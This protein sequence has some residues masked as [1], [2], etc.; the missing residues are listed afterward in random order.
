MCA[1]WQY[2]KR[3]ANS[4]GIITG[5]SLNQCSICIFPVNIKVQTKFTPIFIPD[6]HARKLRVNV[7][8]MSKK[9]NFSNFIDFFMFQQ[10]SLEKLENNNP[11]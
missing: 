4:T 2:R 10:K 11:S 3:D 5:F 8:L 6:K 1:M 7:N 9:L